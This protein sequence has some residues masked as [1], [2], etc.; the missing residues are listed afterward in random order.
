M[1][2]PSIYTPELLTAICLRLG[3]GEPLAEVCRSEGM[4]DPSTVWRW[5]Q[6]DPEV[7]QAIARAR[8]AGE[9][10]L[11]W[12]C[13]QIADTPLI[14]EEQELDDSG[15]V[16]KVKRGDMLGHRKLQIDTRIK[17][18]SKFNPKRW[19]DKLELAGDKERPLTVELVKFTSD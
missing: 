4:P 17:L 1:A 7:S 8:E 2:R 6:A 15:A 19:G 14:G 9:W 3:T 10:A 18:L 5:E 12:E 13:K 16:V 11:A